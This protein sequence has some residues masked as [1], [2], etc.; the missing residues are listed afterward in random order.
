[1]KSRIQFILCIDLVLILTA[2]CW[3]QKPELVVQTGHSSSV[4]SV[5]FSPDGK[6][7]ASGSQDM[8]IKLFDVAT[9]RELRTLAGHLEEVES[10]AFSVDG[11]ILA[12]GSRDETL[13]LWDVATGRNLRTLTGHSSSVN[14]VAFS[15]DNKALASG[16]YDKSIKLWDVATGQE[17]RTLT[18]HSGEVMSVAFSA[19]RKTLA[20]GSSDDTIKLWELASGRELRT[21]TGHSSGVQSVTF[22]GD[23]KTL[24]SGSSDQTIKLWDVATGRELRTFPWHFA[25]QSIAFSADGKALASGSGD[26]TVTIWDVATGQELRRLAGH[27]GWVN[28]V[29]FSADRKTLASGSSDETIK[30]WDLATGRELRTLTGHSSEITSVALSASGKRLATGSSDHTIKL[31]D[32]ATGRQLRTFSA[33]SDAEK[34]PDEDEFQLVAFSPDEKLLASSG[35]E[36]TVTVWETATGREVH[37]LEGQSLVS[38]IAFSAD[39][40][41][42][43]STRSDIKLWDVT[44]GRELRTLAG[45]SDW[46]HSIAFSA[47]GKMLASGSEDKTIKLWDMTTGKELR[48]LT[49]HSDAVSSVAFSADG[50]TLASGSWDKTIK[51]WD[52][53]TGRKLRTL[54]GHSGRVYSVAFIANRQM[55]ASGSEDN[56]IKLWE[57][58][59]G[60]ELRTLTG[61]SNW[62]TSIA[63]SAD[64]KIL[65]SGSVDLTSKLWRVDGGEMLASLIALDDADWA[66]VTPDGLFD[67]SPSA[68]KLMHWI[69]GQESIELQQLKERYYEP[70]LLAKLTGFNKEPLRD[71]AAFQDVK[72]FPSA[73]W[74]KLAADPTK[75][76]L[77]LTDRGGGIGKVQIFVNGREVIADVR[78]P[79]TDP[80][81]KELKREIDLQQF[82]RFTVPG[83]ANTIEVITHNAEGYLASR[84]TVLVYTPS[85]EKKIEP[86]SLLGLVVGVSDYREGGNLGDLNFAAKDADAM[87][88]TFKAA[89]E[90]LFPGRTSVKLL[91][92][93]SD[94]PELK[95]TKTNII[96]ALKEL[97]NNAKSTD[98][99]LLYFAGHGVSYG[100]Q[101]GDFYFLS[102]DA[103]TADLKDPDLRDTTALSSDELAKLIVNI[104]ANKQVMILDTC[105]SGR[106][107]EQLTKSRSVDSSTIR[108]WERMKDRTGLWILA[109]SAADAVSY[110][111]SR[112]GQGVLTYS[113]LKGL[114][115]DFDKALR[116]GEGESAAELVDVS[117]LFNYSADAVPILARGIGGIQKPL[118][119]SKR[120]ARSFDIGRVNAAN[121]EIIP[122]TLEKP[123]YLRSN[124]Q[125]AGRPRDPLELSSKID[126]RLRETSARGL[127]APLVF[128]DLPE[129]PGALRIA[130]RYEMNGTRV[131]VQV[132]VSTFALVGDRIEEKDVGQPFTIEGDAGDVDALIAGIL[133]TAYSHRS[134]AGD[135]K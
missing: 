126:A 51:L 110:E 91:S 56:T 42:L 60:S 4:N 13:R 124:F 85:L 70:G 36:G 77:I 34:D 61:H 35:S 21:L 130:G 40:K 17:L 128:W 27:S 81:R 107:I 119:A 102:A 116:K 32:V 108:A 92:T 120:D 75:A 135:P 106:L 94:K 64:G 67:A 18:G 52:V 2:V 125:L 113:L 84:G 48:T 78:G 19:D 114:K 133:Q 82:E 90:R 24:A 45:H 104:P 54:S 7:L 129:H 87:F 95:P 3:A 83:E 37:K 96:N 16:S 57:R 14:S 15:L 69:V 134:S 65:L 20:S 1:M 49:G 109:G 121:R 98:I 33:P 12:S 62:V 73:Q 43:A 99:L 117:M 74:Q 10:V 71:V 89:G 63:V 86:P 30:F 6:T 122:Y 5:T 11:K 76:E 100:G 50:K 66:V 39:G 59:T 58:A 93:S 123:V 8:R 28:S 26:G 88:T 23:G 103:S 131:S 79:N 29:A 80:N 72:L 44:T 55:L 97:A 132:F 9:G 46:I 111:S 22:S 25:I 101:D 112:Y 105:A 68:Q 118:I 127:N 41:T 47:D 31:W 38:S 115:V 53:G